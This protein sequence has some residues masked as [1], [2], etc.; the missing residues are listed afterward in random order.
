MCW[1]KRYLWEVGIALAGLLFFLVL[2]LWVPLS[3]AA[4]EGTSGLPAPTSATVQLTPTVDVTATMTA[5][6]EDKLRQ[7]IQQ[8][9]NQNEHDLLGWLRTNA[10]IL[11]STLVVVI[12]GLIGLFRWFGDRQGEREKRAEER[13]QSIVEGLGDKKEG[14]KV[15]AAIMLRTFLRPGY[16]QFYSQAFDLA[17]AYL[18]LRHVDPDE[19]EPLDSLT[20]A[21]AIVFKEA[22]PLA[23]DL[24][25]QDPLFIDAIGTRLD[26]AYL[27]RSDLKHVRLPEAY[28]R[29]VNFYRAKI[30]DANLREAKLCYA[31]LTGADLTKTKLPRADLREA[32]LSR[33]D[34]TEANLSGANLAG[35]NIEDAQSL[36][37][38]NLR[39]VNGLT[40]EQLEACKAKGAIIDEDTTNSSSQSVT[41]PSPPPQSNVAQA[42]SAPPAQVNTPP[43][44]DVSSTTSSEPNP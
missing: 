13:F 28:L 27:A 4:Y 14:R 11:L 7:E 20:Q 30:S 18:R 29:K 42:P 33:A 44:T 38:T 31:F 16:E 6:Q 32:K 25:K 40:K 37:N 22:F 34:L 19:P 26:S 1:L 15:G 8:L 23:R 9:K 17:V 36:K 12:G 35:A 24:L 21:L 43:S 5:L 10:A 2:M 39:G 3:A 41:A